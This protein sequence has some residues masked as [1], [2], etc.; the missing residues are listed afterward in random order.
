M[1]RSL[2]GICLLAY[3]ALGLVGHSSSVTVSAAE[4][5]AEPVVAK[6]GKTSAWTGQP[7]PILVT[8]YSPGPFSGVASFDLPE[9]P[10][11]LVVGGGRPVVG[12]ESVDGETVFTQQHE[13]TLYTQRSG[14]IEI[15]AFEVRFSGKESFTS[16]AI[17]MSGRT[18]PLTFESKRP[19]A[20]EGDSENEPGFVLSVQSMEVTQRWSPAEADLVDAGDVVR[21]TIERTATGTTAMMISPIEINVPDGVRIYPSD[22]MVDDR[23]ERGVSSAHRSETIKYQF[24]RA[25]TFT[26]P[27]VKLVWWNT[28][29]EER[30]EEVLPGRTVNVRAVVA[31][32]EKASSRE[33]ESASPVGYLALLVGLAIVAALCRAVVRFL[34]N[35]PPDLEKEAARN[36]VQACRSNQPKQ[37]YAAVLHW[38]QIRSDGHQSA[39]QMDTDEEL[40]QELR[41]LRRVLYSADQA[42]RSWTGG[43][44]EE[45]FSRFR[46]RSTHEQRVKMRAEDL[47]E[48][49][50]PLPG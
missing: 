20:A 34:G 1:S 27:D 36:V 39:T 22:P 23:S 43:K 17:P 40:E 32:S 15:P 19:P 25:G 45:A 5:I 30:E 48:L 8:L 29:S 38:N 21:R 46:A 7:V 42:T 13:L 33:A 4:P 37:A 18:K 9:L 12:S 11:T 44:L 10:Q 50:A 2:F 16:D 28:D 26:L 3:F 31:T 49:N 24:E 41:S 47:P 6:L 14:S 35:R